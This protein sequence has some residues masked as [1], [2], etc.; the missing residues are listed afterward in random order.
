MRGPKPR[1]TAA[2]LLDGNPGKRPINLE[3]PHPPEVSDAFDEPPIEIAEDP[4]QPGALAVARAEWR[5]LAPMLRRCRQV[6][7]ADRTALLALCVEWDRYLEAR[8]KAFPRV[9]KT[10]SGYF[11]P[12]PWLAIQTKALSLCLKLWPELGLTPSSRTRVTT[13]G[14]GPGGDAFSEFDT[15]VPLGP[16]RD[17]PPTRH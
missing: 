13:E 1:P 15:A 7:E 14:P 4:L 3:E 6:T 11:M 10:Q 12:N 5:R 17:P 8:A 9:V 16:L 2:K